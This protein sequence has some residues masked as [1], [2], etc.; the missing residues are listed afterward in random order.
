MLNDF[1]YSL[2]EM[3]SVLVGCRRLVSIIG[4]Q[5]ELF[6]MFSIEFY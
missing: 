2:G 1:I 3:A 6:D 4:K 5:V